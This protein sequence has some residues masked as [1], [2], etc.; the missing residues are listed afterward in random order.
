M[1]KIFLPAF[2]LSLL[3]FAGNTFAQSK[4]SGK[5]PPLQTVPVVDLKRYAGK[6]FEIARYPNKFQKKCVGNTTASYALKPDGN[7]NVLNQCLVKNG[8]LESATGE[9]KVVEGSSNSKLEV[10]FAPRFMSFLS[11]VWGDYWIVDLDGDYKYA[12]VG[13]PK[14]EYLWILSRA[15]EMTD[16]TYQNILRRVEKLGFNPAKLQKT[17]QNAEAVKGAVIQKQ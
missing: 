11:A 17:P 5:Q 12:A 4:K 8:T 13:D 7:I 10:R 9:A 16:A 2:L 3:V 15:P 14:R 6:W 1:K